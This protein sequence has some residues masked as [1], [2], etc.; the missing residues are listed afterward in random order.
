M[1]NV[2]SGDVI[3]HSGTATIL[4]VSS[5]TNFIVHYNYTYYHKYSW[6]I[7]FLC[8]NSFVVAKPSL[9][10]TE[11]NVL[12]FKLIIL[13]IFS[14]SVSYAVAFSKIIN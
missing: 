12:N 11:F 13:E 14:K 2:C 1:F 3:L 6:V 7:L 9:I 10:E 4:M 5:N 8:T